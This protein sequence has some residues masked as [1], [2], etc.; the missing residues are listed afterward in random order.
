MIHMV[1][2]ELF[3][4][5]VRLSQV[6]PLSR[7]SSVC[8]W[9]PTS[10]PEAMVLGMF[11]HSLTHL[12]HAYK[13]HTSHAT[14]RMHIHARAHYTTFGYDLMHM[15]TSTAGPGEEEKGGRGGEGGGR[16]VNQ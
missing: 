7:P 3:V 16:A 11:V 13:A 6:C 9:S 8:P 15:C 10:E 5:L 4:S 12:A 1:N 14:T 2:I